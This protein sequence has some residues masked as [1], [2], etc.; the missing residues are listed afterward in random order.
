MFLI[1]GR[2]QP[3]DLRALALGASPESAELLVFQQV[4]VSE[5]GSHLISSS[6]Q[7]VDQ[8]AVEPLLSEI[9]QAI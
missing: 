7:T 3:A 5:K 9:W 8:Q 6:G 4:A 2:T 1:T